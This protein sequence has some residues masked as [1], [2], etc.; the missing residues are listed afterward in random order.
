MGQANAALNCGKLEKLQKVVILYRLIWES[1]FVHGEK[2]CEFP[3][4]LL[5]TKGHFGG[6]SDDEKG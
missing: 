6:V 3:R 4:R 5:K 2:P 1:I